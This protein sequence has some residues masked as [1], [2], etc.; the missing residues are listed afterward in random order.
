VIKMKT[1]KTI[2][3]LILIFLIG[4]SMISTAIC[5]SNHLMSNQIITRNNFE[6]LSTSKILRNINSLS[7]PLPDHQAIWG[8]ILYSDGSWVPDGVTV[9]VTDLD[10][11][12]SMILTTESSITGQ[13][14]FY[15][16]DVYDFDAEDGHIIFVN[17]SYGGCEG[18]GSAIVNFSQGPSIRSDFTI[19]G[20]LPPAIPSQPSGP[21]TG[22]KNVQYTYSTN[23]TDPNADNIYY[24]FNW[25]DGTNSGWIGPYMSGS[26]VSASHSWSNYGT[27]HVKVK[28][29]DTYG[30]ELGILWSTPLNVTISSQPPNPPSVPSGPTFLNINQ[31]GTYSTNTIDPEG[32]QVQYRFDWDAAGS[33]EYSAWTSLVPSGTSVTM[34]HAWTTG[35]DY[36]VQAQARDENNETSGWSNGLTVHVNSPPNA[37]SNPDPAN[38]EKGVDINAILSWMGGD[39][40]GDSV[41]YDVYFGTTSPP[42]KVVDNQSDVTYD[43]GTM[44]HATTYYWKIVAWDV[45]GAYTIGTIWSF[46]TKTAN[47]PP[48]PPTITGPS[49]GKI[50]VETDY[51][52][53]AT[54]PDGDQLSYFIDWSDGT[55]SSWIGPYASGEQITR[56][57]SWAKKGTYLLK[58]K[59]KDTFGDESDWGQLSV[60]M[61]CS[62]NLPFIHFWEQL[63][64]RFP[65][66]FPI[67][68]HLMGY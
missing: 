28:A 63:F 65:H 48:N 45:Y 52:F 29:K 61:P 43:P 57:H 16:V 20:N 8:A 5:A 49:S 59:A 32:D 47:Q 10:N 54:D 6:K 24:W 12:A 21:T 40:N 2:S 18:N 30:A 19:Y 46:T 56:S 31:Q 23:T 1:K 34:N 17:V 36:V 39:P 53:T 51:N 7:E 33:H 37:P 15:A 60:T 55:N 68:R 67:L 25:D 22:Y 13:T 27:F 35:G 58:A 14:G 3:I 4:S 42:P 41:T 38:G 66:A 44:N 50:K 11:G 64:Q 26:I 62:Y 9:T